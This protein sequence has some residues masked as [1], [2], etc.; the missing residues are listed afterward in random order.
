MRDLFLANA[1]VVLA[2]VSDPAV[3]N[4]WDDDSILEGQTIGSLA[5]HLARGSVWVV[6]DYLDPDPPDR[7]VDFEIAAENTSLRSPRR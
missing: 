1:A 6:G 5:G 3:A 4:A 7:P 2:A